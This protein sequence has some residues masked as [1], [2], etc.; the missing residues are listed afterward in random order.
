MKAYELSQKPLKEFKDY[1]ENTPAPE[2]FT[3]EEESLNILD[4]CLFNNNYDVVEYLLE[5]HDYN[6][7]EELNK[8]LENTPLIYFVSFSYLSKIPSE[9][10][11]KFALKLKL[12]YNSLLLK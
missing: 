12:I 8:R 11:K 10:N 3:F 2:K 4:F 7:K 1:F 6:L 5:N 9:L